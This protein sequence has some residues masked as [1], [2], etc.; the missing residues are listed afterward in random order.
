MSTDNHKVIK[1]LITHRTIIIAAAIAAI[2]VIL[3]WASGTSLLNNK[4]P[5]NALISQVGGILVTTGG[6]T[7]LWDLRG[8]RDVIDE[9]LARTNTSFAIKNSGIRDASMDWKS[10]DWSNYFRNSKEIEIFISYGSTWRKNHWG[11][12]ENFAKDGSRSLSIF[13]PDPQDDLSVKVLAKRY[14]NPEN[15]IRDN[16]IETAKEIASLS[17]PTGAKIGISYRKGDPTFTCYRFDQD[18][19]VTLYSNRRKRGSVPTF[20]IREGTLSE[21]FREDLE[22]VKSQ[23]TEV[24]LSSLA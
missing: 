9:V 2:G 19:V 22:A 3:L 18:Y 14:D 4:P 13:L 17:N 11:E 21:F 23:S 15:K 20:L 24:P 1:A 16:I 5:W 8:R 7:I 12:L 10:I 6:L